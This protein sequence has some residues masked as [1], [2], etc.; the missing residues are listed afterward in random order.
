M[1]KH[2]VI[3]SK[4]PLGMEQHS[5]FH[6]SCDIHP[7]VLLRKKESH[8]QD[9]PPCP[10][11]AEI[12]PPPPPLPDGSTGLSKVPFQSLESLQRQSAAAYMAG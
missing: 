9:L 12:K 10:A 7:Q 1:I 6:F 5:W 3:M 4:F 11:N 2:T 8:E